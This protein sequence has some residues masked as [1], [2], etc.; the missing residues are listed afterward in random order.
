M[1]HQIQTFLLIHSVLTVLIVKFAFN[2]DYVNKVLSW[3]LHLLKMPMTAYNNAK[4]RNIRNIYII[5]H[6]TF[7]RIPTETTIYITVI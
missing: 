7:L 1:N 2:L 6:A 4:V 3:V 5:T